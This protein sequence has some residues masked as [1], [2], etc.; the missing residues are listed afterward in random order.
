MKDVYKMNSKHL[1]VVRYRDDFARKVIYVY[2]AFTSEDKLL[3]YLKKKITFRDKDE[4]ILIVDVTCMVYDKE[5]G[6]YRVAS[7]WEYNEK[8]DAWLWD[9]SGY[10]GRLW[11]KLPVERSSEGGLEKWR[12]E[13]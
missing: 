1:F 9:Y 13:K 2:R 8:R 10:L 4:D 7:I 5:L 12:N 11:C 6:C 3:S